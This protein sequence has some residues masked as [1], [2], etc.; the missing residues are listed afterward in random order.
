MSDAIHGGRWPR[1][2]WR[3][4][5]W[6]IAL[7]LLL[8][9]AVAMQF[10]DAVAWGPGDFALAAT[11]FAAFGAAFELAVRGAQDRHFRAAVGLALAATLLIVWSNLAVG[12]VGSEGEPVNLLF[13][14]VPMVGL[15][16]ALLA[17]LRAAGM[18]RAMLVTALAQLLAGAIAWPAAPGEAT[19]A[20]LLLG[21]PWLAAA[22]LF[23][24]AAR[25]QA[26]AATA[27]R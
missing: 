6:G 9:P 5:G 4:L 3:L 25:R 18:A 15:I 12:I 22:A 8:A 24:N 14:A 13:F 7:A 19:L 10:T 21:L 2:R 23:R 16:G 26:R 17:R 27:A 1:R 11:L 20:T